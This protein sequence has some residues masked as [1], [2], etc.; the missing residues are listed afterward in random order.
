MAD[1]LRGWQADPYGVH[2]PRYFSVDGIATRLV[3]DGGKTSQDPPP[4]DPTVA[5]EMASRGA[6]PIGPLPIVP[7]DQHPT[8]AIP[9]DPLSTNGVSRRRPLLWGTLCIVILAAAAITAISL[10]HSSPTPGKQP[11]IPRAITVSIPTTTTSLPVPPLSAQIAAELDVTVNDAYA[12]GDTADNDNDVVLTFTI[13]DSTSKDI[14]AFQTRTVL[15]ETDS[16]GR[17]YVQDLLADCSAS[18]A[19]GAVRTTTQITL[20][21][22]N[23]DIQNC[24]AASWGMNEFDESQ[25]GLWNGLHDPGGSYTAPTQVTRI[26]FSD[27]ASLGTAQTGSSLPS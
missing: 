23:D 16:L 15:T 13:H 24:T 26:T 2:E 12:L 9:K 27:G 25:I 5:A 19:A 4:P 10:I 8:D 18:L 21:T 1:V 7:V 11:I 14:A 17:T 3:S 6:T 20:L 22:V